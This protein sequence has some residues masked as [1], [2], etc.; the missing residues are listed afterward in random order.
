VADSAPVRS[1]SL[2]LCLALALPALAANDTRQDELKA[3]QQRIERL[4]EE[5]EQSAEDR[6]EAA[7]SLKHS[8][9]RISE[10][11]R[12]LRDLQAR[13]GA[14]M[15]ELQRIGGEARGVSDEAQQQQA[16]LAELL[17]QRYRQRGDDAL[18]I[19]LSGRDP[20]ETRR[21]LAYLGYVGAARTRLIAQHRA[22]LR[23]LDALRQDSEAKKRDLSTV[24]RERLAQ[25][26]ALEKEKASRQQVLANLSARIRDQRREIGNLQRDEQRLSKLIE[27]LRLLAEARKAK[28]NVPARPGEKV[29]RV[30]DASLAELAFTKMKGRLAFPV[31]GEL[32]ARFG[33]ARP[34]GGPAWKGLF[35]RARAGLDVRAVATGEVV[36]ADWLRGF[37]NLLILDHGD[38]YLSLYSNN[39]SLYKPLGTRVKAGDA[40]A[41]VGNSGGQD[42]VGLYFELRHQGRPFD[43]LA[44]VSAAR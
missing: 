39:E 34:G 22:T 10:V 3:I 40:I 38:G 37:G 13:Q 27:R 21:R 28:K 31:A 8:E 9:R 5:L 12:G 29:G 16:R 25:K 24:E 26:T 41:S 7:D 1:T 20:G 19:L 30:V 2:L 11:K 4:Q 15:A 35:I 23:Q 33:Q 32:T 6:S 36:F 42:E 44:W 17:R 43:P 18:R 14:L